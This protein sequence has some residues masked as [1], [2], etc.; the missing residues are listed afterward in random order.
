MNEGSLCVGGWHLAVKECGDSNKLEEHDVWL[1]I[2]RTTMHQRLGP[3]EHSKL[4]MRIL[5][6]PI[7]LLVVLMLVTGGIDIK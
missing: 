6:V 2:S 1:D 5:I 7:L 3:A 4:C